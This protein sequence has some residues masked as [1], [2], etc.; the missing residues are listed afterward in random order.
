MANKRKR[1]S[2]ASPVGD[3]ATHEPSPRG[4]LGHAVS[5]PSAAPLYIIGPA[6]V[7]WSF[8]MVNFHRADLYSAS[9]DSFGEYASRCFAAG[10]KH[11]KR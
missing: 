7:E 3:R 5:V 4:G 8:D 10:G 1:E 9:F 6:T 11:G 2:G